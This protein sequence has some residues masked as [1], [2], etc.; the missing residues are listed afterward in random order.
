[1]KALIITAVQAEA[2]AIG[3]FSNAVVVAGG[4]G[5]TNAAASTTRS[6][7]EDGPFSMVISAGIAGILPGNEL[8]IGDVLIATECVYMEE[9]IQTPQGFEDMDAMGFP[10]GDFKGNHVPV[11]T[12]LLERCP[13][14]FQRGPIATVATC[15]GTDELAHLV[16]QRTGSMAEAMEGAAV[17][18]AAAR[19]DVPG[20]E[21]RSMS[22]HTGHRASQKWDIPKALGSLRPVIDAVLKSFED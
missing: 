19:M 6:L 16:H 4:V 2:D 17:V 22:N 11:D 3:H 15:S 10:L 12:A 5:R 8:A 1:M 21:I 20:I 18:H 9:G 14:E 13:V 7:L